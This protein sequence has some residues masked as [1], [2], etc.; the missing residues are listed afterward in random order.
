MNIDIQKRLF[1]TFLFGFVLTTIFAVFCLLINKPSVI[2]ASTQTKTAVL[3]NVKIAFDD[4]E[5]ITIQ[6]YNIDG[7]NYIRARDITNGLDMKVE[8]LTEG[9]VGI[10]IFPD[11]PAINPS[12]LENL[13]T[14]SINVQVMEGE[15]AYMNKRYPI[16]CFNYADRYYFKVADIGAATETRL[17]EVIAQ[18]KGYAEGGVKKGPAHDNFYSINVSWSQSSETISISRK[19][20]DLWSVFRDAGGN[21]APAANAPV[22]FDPSKSTL[23]AAVVKEMEAMANGTWKP[24]EPEFRKQAPLKSPPKA[25]TR[26][27][28]ILIDD[29]ISPYNADGSIN[30]DNIQPLYKYNALLTNFGQCAWYAEGRFSEITGVDGRNNKYWAGTG[31]VSGW[32]DNVKNN[33]CPD[34]IAVTDKY[35]V[36]EQ[37]IA[38][39]NGHVAIVEY[40][41]RDNNGNPIKIYVTEANTNRAIMPELTAGKYHHEYDGL[42]KVFDYDTFVNKKGDGSLK[43]YII[44]K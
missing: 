42:V 3:N 34:V 8:A 26:L 27:A 40:V 18:T 22:V 6:A 17:E 32:L 10:R 21:S 15:L 35:D 14:Q 44:A 25:G 36:K 30:E 38:V 43:G 13:T 9:A 23:P 29:S 11:N 31:S 7:Y 24:I 12:K 28:N 33:D 5:S 19:T 20:T 4:K 39:F 41:E 1:R 16:Q 2:Y 37:S